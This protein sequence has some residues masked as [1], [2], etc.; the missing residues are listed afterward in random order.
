[1]KHKH[2]DYKLTAVLYHLENNSSYANTCKV[3]KCSERSLKRWLERYEEEEAIKRHNR[4]PVAYKVKKEWVVFA[5]QKLEENEQI[6]MEELS[7]KMEEQFQDFNITRKHLGD[8]MRDINKTRKRTRREHFPATRFRRPI[9]IQTELNRFFSVVDTYDLDKIISIDETSIS[10]YMAPEYSRCHLGKRCILKTNDNKVFQKHTMVGAI[11]STGLVDYLFYEEGGMTTERLIEFLTQV[12]RT[13][14]NHLVILDNAP[15]HR[16]AIV[17]ETIEASGNKLVYSI[18]YTPRTNAIEN[19]FSQLKH[20]MKLDRD[21]HYSR[22][23][24]QH[25][26]CSTKNKTRELSPYFPICL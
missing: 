2:E 4:P 10:Y 21:T 26:R 23:T 14:R 15:A 13:K 3:F 8:V 18:P 5:T 20:Y 24:N 1:M 25:Q 17:K 22:D 16:K 6:T 7:K 11:S 9:S 12:L 19:Y